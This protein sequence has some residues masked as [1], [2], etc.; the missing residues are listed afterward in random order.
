MSGM[1]VLGAFAL[2]IVGGFLAIVGGTD[3]HLGFGFVI[4]GLGV[5]ALGLGGVCSSVAELDRTP[6][7]DQ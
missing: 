5:I 6:R 7:R 4:I 3:I 1:M 2:W